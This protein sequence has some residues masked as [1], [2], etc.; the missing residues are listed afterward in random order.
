MNRPAELRHCR[1]LAADL[2]TLTRP[3]TRSKGA[4]SM[5]VLK[6]AILLSSIVLGLTHQ[7]HAVSFGITFDLGSGNTGTGLF[8]VATNGSTYYASSGYLDISGGA[9]AGTWS[10]YTAGGTTTYP[11]RLTSPGGGYWYNNAVYLDG[12]N[13]QFPA[14]NPLLDQYAL[15]FIQDGSPSNE[16]NLWAN[17]DGSYTLGGSIGGYQNFS[18]VLAI[19]G[20]SGVPGISITPAP[21]PT[22][23]A[24]LLLGGLLMA[25]RS[26]RPSVA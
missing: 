9:A 10:L 19:N 8:E 3:L 26:R 17:A 24:L 25:G 2:L 12:N 16:L 22:S 5:K 13:P 11:S 4:T 21:E 20:N 7:A 1:K 6:A 23:A 18:V 14:T 15:L